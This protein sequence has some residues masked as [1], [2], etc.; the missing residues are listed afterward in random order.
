MVQHSLRESYLS[1]IIWIGALIMI[2]SLIG[3]CTQTDVD[4]WYKTLNR[5]SLTPPN[6]V[7]P[8]A[9]TIL[10]GLIGAAGWAI[11]NASG[12]PKL[13]L[14]KSLYVIQ[15]L[16]N[17]SW[18]PLFFTLHLTGMS[19][20][21]ILVMDLAVASI[22]YLA[23]GKFKLVALLVMPYLLW[24]LFATHLNFYIWQYN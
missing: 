17:W 8:I 16:L 3:F 22:I 13:K 14:I 23:Y 20:L 5:S 7:F 15:L 2:G 18:T 12:F 21:C 10:Y 6:Y 9:W 1:L 24:I 19:L 11:W 4:I